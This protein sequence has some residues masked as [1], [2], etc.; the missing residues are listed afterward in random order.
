MFN[1]KRSIPKLAAVGLLL[2]GAG[3]GEGDGGNDSGQDG[4]N[5]SGQDGGNDSGQDGGT[6]GTMGDAG[7]LFFPAELRS[8][9]TK[10]SECASMPGIT[11]G[12]SDIDACVEHFQDMYGDSM[13]AACVS[14]IESYLDCI[15][16]DCTIFDDDAA[17]DTC[18]TEK[19]TKDT[20]CA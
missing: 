2:T 10:H 9:C 1:P 6:G 3:C 14:A 8:T 16:N 4:G 13:N 18:A 15:D 7:T 5:D 19:T 11:F 17:N 20:D 12:Y